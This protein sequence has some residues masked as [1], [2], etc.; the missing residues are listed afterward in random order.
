MKKEGGR[1]EGGREGE[2]EEGGREGGGRM[3]TLT[4]HSSDLLK[5]YGTVSG[6]G[7]HSN[8][9]FINT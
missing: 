7:N 4:Q 2:S 5:H 6:T 1:E 8:N 3:Q 9:R